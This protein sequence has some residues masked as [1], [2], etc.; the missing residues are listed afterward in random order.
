MSRAP[1]D[2][3][4]PPAGMTLY[5][6]PVVFPR[7]HRGA[8]VFVTIPIEPGAARARRRRKA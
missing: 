7:D 1:R 8:A 5:G 6:V 4:V 3:R 2:P